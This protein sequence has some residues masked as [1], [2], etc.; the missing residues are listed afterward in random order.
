[1][2]KGKTSARIPEVYHAF[3]SMCVPA[4]SHFPHYLMFFMQ[5]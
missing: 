1:M 4:A 2:E 3:S 5:I